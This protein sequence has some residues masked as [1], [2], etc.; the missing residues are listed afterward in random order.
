MGSVEHENDGCETRESM[1]PETRSPMPHGRE[2]G[3]QLPSFLCFFQSTY[4][5]FAIRRKSLNKELKNQE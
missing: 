5:P 2:A 3:R 1:M 4:W